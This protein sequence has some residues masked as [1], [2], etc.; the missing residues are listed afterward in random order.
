M[1][2]KINNVGVSAI[3]LTLSRMINLALK[4]TST[5]LIARSMTL[6]D[7]GTY[8]ELL[9]VS[10]LIVSFM[11][12]GLPSSLS[13]F[14]PSMNPDDRAKFINFYFIA[15]TVIGI[16]CAIVLYAF[17]TQISSFYGNEDIQLYLFFLI[18]IPWASICITSRSNMLIAFSKTQKEILYS[19]LNSVLL[20]LVAF[21]TYW[22][23]L[24][25]KQYLYYYVIV[26][27]IFAILV[28]WEALTCIKGKIQFYID[29]GL[30]K[31]V[32]NFSIPMG[33]SVMISTISIDLD[34][35]IIGYSMGEQSVAIY[36]NA[37][38][39]LPFVYVTSSFSAVILPLIV[40]YINIGNKDCAIR[41]WRESAY[42]CSAIIFFCAS[43][44][45]VFAPQIITILYSEKYLSGV[46]IFRIYSLT[47][48]LRI[49]YWGSILNAYGK[50]RQILYNSI[51]CL[52]LNIVLSI[53]LLNVIGFIGPAVATFIS[54]LFMAIL[55]LLYSV[56][57]TKI[58][59]S[60]IFSWNKILK[61]FSIC[62]LL[63]IIMF[64][65]VRYLNVQTDFK[66]I[67]TSFVIVLLVGV[68]YV[69]ILYKDIMQ[70]WKE[71]TNHK[72]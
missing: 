37:G 39:E 47:L 23:D 48:L 24:S 41:L 28:Y 42:I 25:L 53:V 35:L 29:L 9:V 8:S 46:G 27:I 51:Y 52:L 65:I 49:T 19:I 21:F 4:I 1:G 70:S 55:Q 59:M 72:I 11:V 58:S 61:N 54:I 34:K 69:L 31:N 16:L 71:C 36:A 30:I 64:L 50:S 26:E 6:S 56:R 38:K 45:I 68:V 63:T 2:K 43:I 20:L 18:V 15:I 7:Y 14:I 60:N 32:L 67:S 5:M 3:V 17:R 13:Y 33:I 12:I 40:K 22:Y 57:L 66:S 62:T 10:S 44:S